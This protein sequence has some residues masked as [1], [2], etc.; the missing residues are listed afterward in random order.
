MTDPVR[1]PST[2]AVDNPMLQIESQSRTGGPGL[3]GKEQVTSSPAGRWTMKF[4]AFVGARIERNA[5][6]SFAGHMR[7]RARTC[8]VGPFDMQNSPASLAYG[9]AF[10]YCLFSDGSTFSDGSEFFMNGT[11]SFMEDDVA[12]LDESMTITCIPAPTSG[13]YFGLDYD[14]V[15]LGGLHTWRMHQIDTVESLSPSLTV[16]SI[17][18]ASPGVITTTTNHNLVAGTGVIFSTSAALP[19]GIT[20][21]VTYYVIAAGLTATQFRISATVGGSAIN[22]SGSQSGTH[23]IL[24]VLNTYTITFQPPLRQAYKAGQVLNFENPLCEMRLANDLSA[25]L[26]RSK[27]NFSNVAVELVEAF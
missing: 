19:T 10:N 9:P 27:A 6:V 14:G 3:S 8:L 5:L 22:T 17:S 20:A 24:V 12:L 7:G 1:W 13:Q 4:D 23:S 25:A 11:Y 16:A 18:I 2:L 21:G 15:P 26:T